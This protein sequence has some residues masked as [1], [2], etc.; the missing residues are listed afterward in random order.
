MALQSFELFADYY[1][2]YL[3]DER[4]SGDLSDAWSDAAVARLLAVAPGAIGVGT[5]RNTGVPVEV[6]VRDAPPVDDDLARW[7]RVNECSLEVPSGRLVIAGATD[8]FPDAAR[9]AVRSG[10]YRVR[11]YYGGLDTVSAD[12]L[13]GAD[14]YR[15]VLWPAA[16]GP[17][18]GLKAPVT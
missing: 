7:D 5:V 11:I 17:T 2:F 8:Y 10:T 13:A 6:D 16:P 14:R 12:G 3:Q 1:Q 18:V 9:I 15:I 4:A